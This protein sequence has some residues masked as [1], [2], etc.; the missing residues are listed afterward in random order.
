MHIVVENKEIKEGWQLRGVSRDTSI[1]E[2]FGIEVALAWRYKDGEWSVYSTEYNEELI[3]KSGYKKLI[4]LNAL[5]GFW[6]Y[7]K[8]PTQRMKS[9]YLFYDFYY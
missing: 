1:S 8:K 9:N 2:E 7:N 4:N 6:V 3:E 5:D